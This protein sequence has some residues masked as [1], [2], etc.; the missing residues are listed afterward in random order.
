MPRRLYENVGFDDNGH[1]GNVGGG[2]A[3][4]PAAVHGRSLVPV[5]EQALLGGVIKVDPARVT[6]RQRPYR[7][8]GEVVR[9]AAC[10]AARI[11]EVSGREVGDLHTT[12]WIWT[13]RR[14]TTPAP[15]GLVDK[16]TKG[17]RAHQVPV[18]EEI[19][20]LVAQ[21]ILAAGPDPDAHKLT[22]AGTAPSA[23]L[24]A[25]RAPPSLPSPIVVAR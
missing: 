5:V 10:T 9:S 1:V 12:Q 2:L 16:R 3:G 6:G 25:L 11:G 14:Q 17:K 15:G 24:G 20:P 21:R 13:V 22:A 4:I 7:G 23:H 18:I 19:R 8:W